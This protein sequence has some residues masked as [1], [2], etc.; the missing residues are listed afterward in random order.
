MLFKAHFENLSSVAVNFAQKQGNTK[1][2][3]TG[4]GEYRL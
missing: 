3:V 2:K 1:E 4:C